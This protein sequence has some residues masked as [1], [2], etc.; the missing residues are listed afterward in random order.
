MELAGG[1]DEEESCAYEF[2]LY[3]KGNRVTKHVTN[4]HA[5]LPT[6]NEFGDRTRAYVADAT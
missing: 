4:F 6:K 3:G 5:R 2:V 1:K